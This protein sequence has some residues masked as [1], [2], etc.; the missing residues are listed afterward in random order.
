MGE[1]TLEQ[2]G[3]EDFERARLALLEEVCDPHT[4][5]QLDAIAVGDGWRCLDAGAGAGSA[6]R[7]LAERVGDA[8][9]VLAVDLDVR[10]LD[11]LAGDRVEVRQHDLL[12]DPLPEGAFDVVHARNL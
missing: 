9:S 8:G 12:V 1:Y 10:L 2:T 7:L 5:R 6:T 11:G 4:I 3:A